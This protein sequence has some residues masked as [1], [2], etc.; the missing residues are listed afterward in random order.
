MHSRKRLASVIDQILVSEQESL[1][2]LEAATVDEY[3]KLND[4]CDAVI[5][6][7]KNRKGK[8]NIQQSGEQCLTKTKKE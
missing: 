3:K 7:I 2:E 5:G 6:K 8:K 1:Q 4:K